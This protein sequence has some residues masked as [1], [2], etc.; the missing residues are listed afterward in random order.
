[1]NSSK[2][3]GEAHF[4][5]KGN[6]SINTQIVNTPNLQIIDY[7]SGFRESGHDMHCFEHTK[8]GIAPQNLLQKDEWCWAD[9]GDKLYDW[10][11]IPYKAP[12]NSHPDAATFN[13]NLSK[14]RI[15]SEH[16]IG[17]LKG[18]F[19]SLKELRVLIQTPEDLAFATQWINTCIILHAFYMDYE[20]NEVQEDLL[21]DGYNHERRQREE[22]PRP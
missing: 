4:D 13:F 22:N 19:Q 11:I 16:A 12:A 1:M 20:V 18:R 8:L 9:Q 21:E 17:Y 15:R 10:L 5:R 3:Y 2:Y 6:Y 7:A 14:L